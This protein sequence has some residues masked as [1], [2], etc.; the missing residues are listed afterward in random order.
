MKQPLPNFLPGRL[1]LE[2]GS[3][4]DYRLLNA[5]HYLAKRPATWVMVRRIRYSDAEDD[6]IVAIA[7][8]SYPRASCRLRDQTLGLSFNSTRE[9]L[10]FVN[11]NIRAISRVIVHPQFRSLGLSTLLVRDLIRR[12]P[13]RYIES[14]AMM[15]RAHPFFVR[16]GMK[17]IDPDQP[18][19]PVYF[20]YD[21]GDSGNTYSHGCPSSPLQIPQTLRVRPRACG[22][23]SGKDASGKKPDSVE[24]RVTGHRN[25]I[26]E[27]QKND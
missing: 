24:I 11:Q 6:R 15:G 9:S 18:D 17:Q 1:I 3:A 10:Q 22:E 5:F 8:L 27:G 21:R 12:C 26:E 23:V 13:T 7:V 14:V 2:S 25:R 4:S 19:D 16:A 20:I